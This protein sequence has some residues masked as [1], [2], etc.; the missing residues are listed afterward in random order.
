[1]AIS[2]AKKEELV[3]QYIEKFKNSE[4]VII[5]DYRGL[6]VVD[7]QQLRTK[8]REVEG[9]F[10]VVKNTLIQRAL[11]EVGLPVPEEM[12]VGPL[13]VGFCGQNIPGVAKVITDFAKAN[14]LLTVKGGLMG[15]RIIDDAAVTSLAKLPPLET[16][17]AQLLGL[18]NAPAS[19]LVGVVSGGIRQLVNVVHAYSEKSAEALADA[20]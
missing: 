12:L 20:A 4:A 19:Q 16:V 1:M 8:V 13:G 2:R 3:Q 10:S 9:S 5:T 14:E 6:T 7:L 17:R 18:I 11:T 15:S